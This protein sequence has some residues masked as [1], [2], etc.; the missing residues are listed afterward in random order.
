MNTIAKFLSSGDVRS[1]RSEVVMIFSAFFTTALL[2][3]FA[4]GT[5]EI[6]TTGVCIGTTLTSCGAFACI[7]TCEKVGCDF[8][9]GK[10]T[11]D[12]VDCSGLENNLECEGI[13]CDWVDFTPTPTY[14]TRVI[15]PTST[16]VTPSPTYVTREF[17]SDSEIQDLYTISPTG[18]PTYVTSSEFSSDS[19]E[20]QDMYPKSSAP[21][22]NGDNINNTTFALASGANR[23]E[24]RVS[25]MC[26]FI[27]L[28][29]SMR[30][31]Q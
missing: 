18:S 3:N 9:T 24:T 25:V 30:F 26:C 1:V 16:Y 2:F 14:V 12:V 17:S 7:E 20:L 5:G 4:Q 23:L 22:D 21:T 8:G 15:T 27:L 31:N 13:G 29:V 19:S 28:F 10:C 11:G 6:R